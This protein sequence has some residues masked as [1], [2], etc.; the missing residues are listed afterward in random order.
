M[1]LITKQQVRMKLG[2]DAAPSIRTI[3]RMIARGEFVQPI[4]VAPRR[5]MFEEAEVDAW[6]ESRRRQGGARP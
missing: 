1:Q 5:V 4:Q 2:G 3:E 6:L